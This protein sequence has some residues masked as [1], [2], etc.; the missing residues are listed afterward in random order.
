M[1]TKQKKEGE[2]MTK[3]EKQLIADE[4]NTQYLKGLLVHEL[5]E[6]MYPNKEDINKEIFT[7]EDMLRAIIQSYALAT[8]RASK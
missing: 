5:L 2:R 6:L 8:V 7:Y 3:K 1:L 4:H